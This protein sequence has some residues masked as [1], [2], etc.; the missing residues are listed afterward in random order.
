MAKLHEQPEHRRWEQGLDPSHKM[1]CDLCCCLRT[2]RN[3]AM[4]YPRERNGFY[5]VTVASRCRHCRSRVHVAQKTKARVK[6]VKQFISRVNSAFSRSDQGA[7]YKAAAKV[8]AKLG[9]PG[10]LANRVV[11]FMDDVK[12]SH[13]A[14]ANLI[15]AVLRIYGSME[16]I[17][18][19]LDT[20]LEDAD[21]SCLESMSED[22][23]RDEELRRSLAMFRRAGYW[24]FNRRTGRV[25]SDKQCVLPG[26][27]ALRHEITPVDRRSDGDGAVADEAAEEVRRTL[28]EIMERIG[29]RR[30]LLTVGV[31]VKDES[32][33]LSE[34]KKSI[35]SSGLELPR[36][37]QSQHPDSQ[38]A[39]LRRSP[40]P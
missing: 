11:E 30:M 38:P 7:A 33:P 24:I 6:L 13:T 29:E 36:T 20:D 37:E 3:F 4:S 34:S 10:M 18:G 15:T 40:R 12:V 2:Q 22:Q 21:L 5:Y 1:K 8:I 16:Q 27:M 26:V 28:A 31:A 9:G 23:L 19:R 35:R 25:L 14:K 17:R 32:D 39:I